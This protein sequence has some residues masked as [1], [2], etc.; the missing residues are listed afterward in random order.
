MTILGLDNIR[1]ASI[2]LSQVP[3]RP[4]ETLALTNSCPCLF[5]VV[6]PTL[7][8]DPSFQSLLFPLCSC[9]EVSLALDKTTAQHRMLSPQGH[10][11][12]IAVVT[13]QEDEGAYLSSCSGLEH[14]YYQRR[15]Q[16]RVG[17]RLLRAVQEGGGEEEEE[18]ALDRFRP[19][20]LGALGIKQQPLAVER[21]EHA[22][23]EEEAKG[24]R[25]RGEEKDN[26]ACHDGHQEVDE[27]IRLAR[28]RQV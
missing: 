8:L 19:H 13:H 12:Q 7:A 4:Q 27:H 6:T 14:A 28:S 17:I 15:P 1:L 10:R 9:L 22:E 26:K 2:D 24:V 21:E 20:A 23:A 11:H 16:L 3:S 18:E 5:L 25:G